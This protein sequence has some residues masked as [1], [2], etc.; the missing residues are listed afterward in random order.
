ME[1]LDEVIDD[2][3]ET[4]LEAFNTKVGKQMN[5]FF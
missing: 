5:T 4:E 2:K 1:E 3:L